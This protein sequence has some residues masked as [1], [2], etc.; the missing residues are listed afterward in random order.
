MQPSYFYCFG[1]LE[2]W[3]ELE[4]FFLY[5]C[6]PGTLAEII[7]IV[8]PRS[9][10]I[11]RSLTLSFPD[12]S[13]IQKKWR[14]RQRLFK[15]H[16]PHWLAGWGRGLEGTQS[17]TGAALLRGGERACWYICTS[18]IVGIGLIPGWMLSWSW[19]PRGKI[20]YFHLSISWR[21][22]IFP[23]LWL[24]IPDFPERKIRRN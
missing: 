2:I 21:Y 6:W 1:K 3:P 13:K 23:Q 4:L 14:P 18:R 22:R 8:E 12:F 11:R 10:L 9:W 5:M 16:A 17:R 7:A 19:I 24:N 20:W 15:A